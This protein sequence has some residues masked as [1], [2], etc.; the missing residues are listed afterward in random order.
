MEY[1]DVIDY[2]Q[3]IS[4]FGSKSGLERIEQLLNYLDN[5]HYNLKF[6]HVAGTNGKG[7]TCAMLESILVDAGYKVGLYTSPHLIKYNERIKINNIDIDD[8]TFT[9]IAEIVIDK[10]LNCIEHPTLFEIITAIALCYFNQQKVDYII[11]EVGLG[12]RYDATNIINSPILSIITSISLDHCEILG[13]TIEQISTEKGGIIKENSK[14]ILAFN[15][16]RVY[17]IINNICNEKNSRLYYLDNIK[18]NIMYQ[19]LY[20]T[21]FSIET[22]YY[23]YPQIVLGMIGEYQIYNVATA[24][25]A[26]CILKDIGI[27]IKDKNIYNGL[28]NIHWKARME[29]ISSNPY[30]LFDGAH[31][32]DS[33]RRLADYIRKY[34][35]NR[36][37]TL[38]I[39]VLKNKNYVE[40]INILIPLVDKVVITEV[41]S[42]HTLTADEFNNI[43]SIYDLPTYKEKQIKKAFI[44]AKNITN[45]NDIIICTGSLY[46]LGEL[47]CIIK[48]E[49]NA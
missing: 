45:Q 20:S 5:P 29:L 41:T 48:E 15:S 32:I 22:D 7:S 27:K 17:N 30:I 38:L 28:K 36:S 37:I 44:K 40:M 46:L 33:I 19:D 23:N 9:N 31:N 39:A 8:E 21:T 1:K 6:I 43:I 24:L 47:E 3:K 16:Y 26:V 34:I 12:G 4:T 2:I 18:F 14:T 42:E 35:K 13:N 25:L 11:L 10:C 49:Q